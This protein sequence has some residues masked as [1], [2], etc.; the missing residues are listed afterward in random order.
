MPLPLI[1]ARALRERAARL[2]VVTAAPFD[3]DDGSDGGGD[4]GGEDGGSEDLA[5][6]E[7]AASGR[8]RD[9]LTFIAI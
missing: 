9:S 1:S 6:C 5:H 4:G 3:G 7:V 8:D 2:R